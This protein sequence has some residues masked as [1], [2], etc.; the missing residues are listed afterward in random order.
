MSSVL[1]NK[2]D[3]RRE[4]LDAACHNLKH[5]KHGARLLVNELKECL[6]QY[7]KEDRLTIQ[8]TITYFDNNMGRMKYWKYEK[9]GF[10]IGSGVTEAACKTVVKQRLSQSGMR[11]NLDNAEGMLIARA[12]IST[13]GRWE[14]FWKKYM[15]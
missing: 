4:W 8:K 10:P 6:N 5:Q 3:E 1:K 7:D 2:K 13:E 12:L 14:Q 9:K 15:A 11:W